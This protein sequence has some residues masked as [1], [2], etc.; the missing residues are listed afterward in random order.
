MI[1][2]GKAMKT[3]REEESF[4]IHFSVFGFVN[5][6]VEF[7]ERDLEVSYDLINKC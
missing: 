4:S 6:C 2:R 7:L 1:D 3:K 5:G